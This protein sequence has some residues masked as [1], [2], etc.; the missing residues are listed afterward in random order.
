MESERHETPLAPELADELCVF[1]EAAFSTSYERFRSILAG[2]ELA[3]NRDVVYLVRHGDA[4]AG[5]CHLTTPARSCRLGGLGEVATAPAFRS[6]GIAT[7]LCRL[8]RDEFR[9]SS[10]AALFLG[11]GNPEAARVYRGL[12]WCKLAGA[13]VMVCVSGDESPEAFLVDYFREPGSV[14]AVAASAGMRIAMIPLLVFP[15]DD[16]VLDASA[17]MLS[18]RYA[19]Q[20]SCMGLYPRYETLCEERS[21]SWFG[22]Q[23][24]NGRVVGLSTARLDASS[25]CQV[26]AF[27]HWRFRECWDELI[28]TAVQWGVDAGAPTCWA[29]IARTEEGRRSLYEA[30][31][32]CETGPD[33]TF[34]VGGRQVDAVR[35]DRTVR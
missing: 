6:R 5:T 30:L 28:E 27:V 23:T 31:G 34:D 12:G 29:R 16:M 18:T 32:F 20:H 11:T 8:A 14:N 25:N 26:D 13:N 10:G 9:Q 7:H 15:H 2:E 22:A 1:W 17:G 4:L 21:G 19:V 24:T 3:H 33:G 35:L